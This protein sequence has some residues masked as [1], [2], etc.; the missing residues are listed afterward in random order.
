MES[1]KVQEEGVGLLLKRKEKQRIFIHEKKEKAVEQGR[2]AELDLIMG[3]T[4]VMLRLLKNQFLQEQQRGD[5]GV[6]ERKKCEE[7]R[8]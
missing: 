6:E 8:R 7:Q 2:K 4:R 5:R 3:P 1:R